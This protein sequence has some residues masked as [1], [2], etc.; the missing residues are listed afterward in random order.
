MQS[1]TV[2]ID[3]CHRLTVVCVCVQPPVPIPVLLLASLVTEAHRCQLNLYQSHEALLS[4]IILLCNVHL[5]QQ[6]RQPVCGDAAVDR[7]K[8][9]VPDPNSVTLI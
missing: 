5:E 6:V 8:L 1:L 2:K 4:V 3:W 9:L 7:L